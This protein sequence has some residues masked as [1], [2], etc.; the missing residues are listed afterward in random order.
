MVL[1][2]LDDAVNAVLADARLVE[3]LGA[4]SRTR[5]SGRED[6]EVCAELRALQRALRE[7][8]RVNDQRKCQI[9]QLITPRMEEQR[10][11]AKRKAANEAMEKALVA[12]LRARQGH[13]KKKRGRKAA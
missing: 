1:K 4:E 3:P 7:R 2:V 5:R 12:R 11:I 8:Q 10:Q 9:Y 6:D 13:K